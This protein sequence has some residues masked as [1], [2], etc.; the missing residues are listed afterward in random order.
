MKWYSVQLNEDEVQFFI[1]QTETY[2][3]ATEFAL[4]DVRFEEDR[5]SI[6]RDL[7]LCD[8]TLDALYNY[9]KFIKEV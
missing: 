3:S 2:K 9:K 5:E 8:S 6:E 1:R 4:Q 7:E